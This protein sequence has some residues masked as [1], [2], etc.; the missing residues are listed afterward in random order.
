MTKRQQLVSR[1]IRLITMT[2][3]TLADRL[4]LS[5]SALRRYRGGSRRVSPAL[6]TDLA[7]AMRKHAVALEAMADRLDNEAHSGK[8]D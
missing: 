5:T 3:E 6:L 2:V 1:A 4:D 8:E 7:K